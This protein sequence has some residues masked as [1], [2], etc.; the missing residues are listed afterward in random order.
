M[1]S[2]TESQR[3]TLEAL[4]RSYLAQVPDRIAAIR[5][6]ASEAGRPGAPREV[7]E[8][9]RGLAHQLVGSSAIFGLAR[10]S[11]AA[12]ALEDLASRLVDG[13]AGGGRLDALVG[14][15]ETVGS[16]VAPRVKHWCA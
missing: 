6:A 8:N 9:L 14:E 4:R 2:L 5:R 16:E 3:E 10:L 15:L 13:A 1:T 12:R 11:S 7:L